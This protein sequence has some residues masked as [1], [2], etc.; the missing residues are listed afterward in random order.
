MAM[1]RSNK[2]ISRHQDLLS[3][4]ILYPDEGY[5]AALAMGLTTE[6]L[7]DLTVSQEKQLIRDIKERINGSDHSQQES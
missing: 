5:E 4:L 1:L 2:K 7:P 3:L 6:T